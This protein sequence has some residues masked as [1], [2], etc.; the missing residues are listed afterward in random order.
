LIRA[1]KEYLKRFWPALRLRTILFATLLFVAALPGI[2]AVFLRVYENTLVQQTEAELIAQ[3]A[4]LSGVY[5]ALWQP[6]GSRL[7][8]QGPAPLRPQRPTI[9]LN[10]MPILPEPPKAIRS[11][12]TAD[13]RARSVGAA[14]QPIVQD[15]VGTTLAAIRIMDARG[16]VVLGRG[17]V[18]LSYRHL[19]EVQAAMAGR[20]AT[21]LRRRGD[22]APRYWLEFL[23]RASD[24]RVH[25]ARPVIENRRVTGVIML[26][27]S[28]RGLFLGIYQDLGKI[29]FGVAAIFATLLVLAGLLSRGIAKPIEALSEATQNV[30]RGVVTIPDPP[31]TA[32]I[33]IRALYESFGTMAERIERRSRYLRDFAAAVSHEF[34][35]PIAG[36]RGALEL[37]EEHGAG[38]SPDERQRFLG[39]AMADADRLAHLLQRLLH[40]ARADMAVS[41]EDSASDVV[42]PVRRVADAHQ[43]IAVTSDIPASLPKVAAPAELV[44]AVLATLVENSQQAGALSVKIGAKAAGANVIL[45]VSDDGP[46]ISA[47][48]HERVFEP[49]HTSRRAEGGSGLGLPIARSL[50]ASCSGTIVSRAGASGACFEISLPA[51]SG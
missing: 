37:L 41:P 33:E 28:P 9:D 36:I 3:G 24:L 7:E 26:S 15:T 20:N 45:S 49:F 46:G 5:R 40:L 30:A 34:K 50:L 1:L 29:L 47:G 19:P 14:L 4:V 31:A 12:G 17:D 32:A 6:G 42:E 8:D 2:G 16:T 35:T 43:G 22:Y 51:A 44:E 38:M 13:E 10:A 25:Y 18:G 23:S 21:A 27:R 11:P 39:N 48:D